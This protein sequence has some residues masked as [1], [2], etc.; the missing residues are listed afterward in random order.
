[1]VMVGVQVQREADV[2]EVS[3]QV[4]DAANE[5]ARQQRSLQSFTTRPKR[6]TPKAMQL[7]KE[8]AKVAKL[9]AEIACA[10]RQRKKVCATSLMHT[11]TR[12]RATSIY[13]L[14]PSL[15]AFS[16]KQ[17]SN[18]LYVRLR[19]AWFAE[20]EWFCALR[21]PVLLSDLVDLDHWS[22]FISPSL[23]CESRESGT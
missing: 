20:P 5:L 10:E 15:L 12:A 9:E 13:S 21:A 14:L 1:M 18:A 6:R 7:A 16:L 22:V 11:H 19:R 3:K 2:L 4:E 17:S 23:L 8:L